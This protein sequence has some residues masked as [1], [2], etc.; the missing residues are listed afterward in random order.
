LNKIEIKKKYCRLCGSKKLVTVYKFRKTPIGDDYRKKI[1]FTKFYT[2]KLKRCLKCNFVQLSNVVDVKKVYGDYLYVT[3]TS[4]GLLNHFFRLAKKLIQFG[5]INKNSKVLEIGSNDGT[6]LEFLQKK[7]NFVLG[8]D[9]A[10]KKLIKKKK[11][12]TINAFFNYRLAKKILN[13]FGYFDVIIANNVIANIDNLSDTFKGIEILLGNKGVLVIETF[14]LWGIVQ[15]NLI[16]NVYHEH[17]SYFTIETLNKFAQKFNLK[18]T[19]VEFLKVKGGSLRFFFKKENNTKSSQI[20]KKKIIQ[21]KRIIQDI[22]IKFKKIFQ[23]NLNNKKKF[24]EFFKKYKNK[25]KIYGFGA[26]VGTTTLIYD[27]KLQDKIFCIFDNEKRRFNRFLPGSKIKVL[28]PLFIKNKNI[29]YIII[30]AWRYA[31]IIIKKNS[32]YLKKNIKFIL[33]LPK[34]KI[35]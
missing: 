26:S 29:D 31:N 17:L 30:F 18:L 24:E 33:P 14:A 11:I 2:L 8:V 35:I 9:P 13:K 6:F 15:N 23:I 28:N 25:K 12:N 27:F 3:S 7:V 1:S 34:F 20:I 21:E 16:D 10:A 4:V 32:K 19:Y 5:Y 22:D